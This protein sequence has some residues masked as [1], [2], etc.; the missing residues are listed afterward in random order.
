MEEEFIFKLSAFKHGINE[1]DI[2]NAFKQRMF[3]YAMKDEEHKY[4]LLG[5]ARDGSLLEIIYNVL[6]NDVIN[7]FHAMK[8]RKAYFSL[9]RTRGQDERND[10]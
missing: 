4:L 7:V 1:A 10:R 5:L 9:L 8:C 3:D 2:R 6:E